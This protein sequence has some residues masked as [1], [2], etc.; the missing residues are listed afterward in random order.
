MSLSNG[1]RTCAKVLMCS[2]APLSKIRYSFGFLVNIQDF[3]TSRK[4]LS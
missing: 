3:R 4:I 1:M 2:E